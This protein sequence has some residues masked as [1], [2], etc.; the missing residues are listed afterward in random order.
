MI[1]LT[2]T[3]VNL[4]SLCFGRDIFEG[5]FSYGFCSVLEVF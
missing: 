3:Y 1:C 5:V 2:F 4:V